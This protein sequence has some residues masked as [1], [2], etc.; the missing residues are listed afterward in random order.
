MEFRDLVSIVVFLHCVTTVLIC[1]AV[2]HI[3][4]SPKHKFIRDSIEDSS[5]FS[6]PQL[7]KADKRYLTKLE[8][9]LTSKK[10]KLVFTNS[11]AVQLNPEQIASADQIAKRNGFHNMGQVTHS[12]SSLEFS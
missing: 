12:F 3:K 9:A 10:G 7:S 6:A 4:N 11:W 5:R 1:S 2:P 8:D